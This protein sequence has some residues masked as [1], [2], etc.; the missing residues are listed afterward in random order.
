[1][2]NNIVLKIETKFEC[3]FCN[4]ITSRKSQ[5]NRHLLTAKH[6]I[7]EN[8]TIQQQN[9][10]LKSSYKCN[11]GKAY[12]HR[13]SLYNHKKK[14]N[15]DNELNILT[16]SSEGFKISEE[17]VLKLI[18]E[19]MELRKQMTEQSKQITELIPMIGNNN[20]SNNT[21]INKVNLQFFLN[22]Q[23]KG[24]LNMTDFIKSIEISLEQLN[25]TK[26]KGLAIGLSDAIIENMNKL[27]VYERPL[28]CT[29]AKRETLYIKDEGEWTKDANKEKIKSALKKVS[30][31][32]YHALKNWI[33]DNPDYQNNDDKCMFFAKTVSAIGKPA[34]TYDDKVIKK[35]CAET[36]LKDFLSE[37]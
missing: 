28:H 21:T 26:S 5:F 6:N 16:K 32:N 22:E 30:T 19:N 17:L 27:S 15:Y 35:L 10:T 12:L 31:K 25:N 2:D 4:Y 34:E 18:N 13:A 9:T 33:D 23:C 37:K 11:C 3:K 24:A 8:T 36:Y 7:N 1:M 14:C 20:N 29:D